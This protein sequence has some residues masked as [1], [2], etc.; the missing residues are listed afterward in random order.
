MWR[1]I[2]MGQ[3][4]IID[5]MTKA[6]GVVSLTSDQMRMLLG[7][8]NPFYGP[9]IWQVKR[10]EWPAEEDYQWRRAC[11]VASIPADE[12]R[13]V[14]AGGRDFT[15]YPLMVEECNAFISERVPTENIHIISGKAKGADALGER[16]AHQNGFKLIERPAAWD[17]VEGVPKSALGYHRDGRAYNK[18]AGIERNE[19]MGR[20]ATHAIIFW[21]GQ[22]R[23]T[24]SMIDI[25]KDLGIIHK[26]VRYGKLP[27]VSPRSK[28][29]QY[30]QGSLLG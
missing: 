2:E 11:H 20:I 14:I 10:G 9:G 15:D 8:A 22:S 19:Q 5:P 17:K 7:K 26:V 29:Q 28:A 18:R 6:F 13:I 1:L 23:G 21:D 3:G 16:Y 12:A 24:K 4:K 27:T 30:K 25:C